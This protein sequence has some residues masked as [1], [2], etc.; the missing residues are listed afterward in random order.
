MLVKLKPGKDGH[1]G[2]NRGLVL[3]DLRIFLNFLKACGTIYAFFPVEFRQRQ[4][5][6]LKKR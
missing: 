1:T 4:T 2:N 6:T 5:K 3:T